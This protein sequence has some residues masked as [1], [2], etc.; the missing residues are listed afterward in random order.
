MK[1]IVKYTVAVLICLL[2]AGAF[3]ACEPDRPCAHVATR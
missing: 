3:T 1:K 2:V